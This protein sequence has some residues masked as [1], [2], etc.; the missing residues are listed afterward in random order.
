MPSQLNG[1]TNEYPIEN[2]ISF[3]EAY[4]FPPTQTGTTTDTNAANWAVTGR[5]PVSEP[6]E[7][8]LGGGGS[9]NFSADATL[10]CRLRSNS[11]AM[12]ALYG[13]RNWA[14]GFWV[15]FDEGFN[16]T[17]PNG[18]PVHVVNPVS[19]TPS[20]SCGFQFNLHTENSSGLRYFHIFNGNT[21]TTLDTVPVVVGQWYFIA[22]WKYEATWRYYINGQLFGTA[23]H[24]AYAAGANI[25]WGNIF[26]GYNT[27]YNISNW[28]V[29]NTTSIDSTAFDAQVAAIWTAGTTKNIKHWTGTE[30]VNSN[31]NKVWNGTAW[32]DIDKEYWNGTAWVAI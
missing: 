22:I 1:K 30:W 9:W 24:N 10:G 28:F 15:K 18:F 11:T 21:D 3:A 2:G 29:Q 8:P 31:G 6:N 7:G 5:N 32:I 17:V 23:F 26:Q 20:A 25:N 14:T 27:S 13:D 12:R 19:A 16:P 4:V